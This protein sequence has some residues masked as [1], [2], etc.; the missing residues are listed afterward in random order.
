MV[1]AE[2]APAVLLVALPA[3]ASG[4]TSL[5]QQLTSTVRQAGLTPLAAGQQDIALSP[6]QVNAL[7]VL[8]SEAEQAELALELDRA[9]ELRTEV[10]ELLERAGA[11]ATH[12]GRLAQALARLAANEV[13]AGH[14]GEA[15]RLWRRALA[16]RADLVLD[17]TFSPSVREV[18]DQARADGPTLPPRPGAEP[19]DRLCSELDVTAV[20]WTAVG[21][22]EDGLVF[23]RV[24][25][26]CGD[27]A[28]VEVRQ[29]LEAESIEGSFT[30]PEPVIDA[31]TAEL[32]ELAP[33][34]DGEGDP[35]PPPPPRP[36]YRRWWFYLGLGLLVA[37]A[38]T[39]TG[40]V[41]GLGE[42]QVDLVL[43][44]P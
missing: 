39:T 16:L 42:R 29:Q 27:A 32:A 41:L 43:H 3:S 13:A 12:P 40:L 10:V 2:E 14:R 4:Q 21:H 11:T 44:M 26:H 1:S 23:V 24:L 31:L 5:E 35:P 36:W 18:F 38:A 17:S 30:P 33:D 9:A 20:L 7:D 15:V 28:P 22:D 37:G 25:H 6:D 19:L 8:V 34:R